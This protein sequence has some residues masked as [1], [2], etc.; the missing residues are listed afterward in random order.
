M[1]G[2]VLKGSVL[3]VFGAFCYGMLGTLVKLAYKSGFNTAEVTI[4]QFLIG[5]LGLSLINLCLNKSIKNKQSAKPYKKSIIKLIV[6][7]S[8]LGL[9]S[10]FYYLAVKHIS[11]SIA[12]V[13]LVQAIW[14]SMVWEMIKTKSKPP[15]FKS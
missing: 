4:S 1:K 6:S 11:V 10:V 9:T 15:V 12:I 13:L 3:I 2:N 14:L 5:V 8:S 7:G